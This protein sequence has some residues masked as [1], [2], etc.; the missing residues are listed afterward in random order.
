MTFRSLVLPLIALALLAACEPLPPGAGPGPGPGGPGR[1]TAELQI[2]GQGTVRLNGFPARYGDPVRSG[3]SVEA[4]PRASALIAFDDGTRVQL[5]ERSGPIDLSWGGGEL[6]IRVHGSLLDVVKGAAFGVVKVITDLAEAYV[7]SHV[8]VEVE[9]GRF[10]RFDL[11]DGQ[12]QLVRPASPRSLFGGEYVQIQRGA[13]PEFGRTPRDYA[14]RLMRRFDRWDFA[15]TPV[16]TPES[17]R[18][19]P[20]GQRWDR[21]E[22]TCVCPPETPYLQ[23]GECITCVGGM[24]WTGR[25]CDCPDDTRWDG[26]ECRQDTRRTPLRSFERPLQPLLQSPAII[27]PRGEVWSAEVGRCIYIVQ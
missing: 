2:A 18:R 21:I 22:Q 20:D 8:V 5:D 17:P 3:D 10:T 1:P 27:C 15:A 6:E 9:R 11:F 14:R 13:R 7:Y 25:Q 4:G 16:Y 26:A 19:C 24:V 23:N 12:L